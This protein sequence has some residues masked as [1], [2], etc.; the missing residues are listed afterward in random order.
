MALFT[1]S[2]FVQFKHSQCFMHSSTIIRPVIWMFALQTDCDTDNFIVHE[3]GCKK[4]VGKR[5]STN[6]VLS[7]HESMMIHK[8]VLNAKMENTHCMLPVTRRE[9]LIDASVRS[10]PRL[11][12]E[13][14][15]LQA[16]SSEHS[17]S[18]VLLVFTSLYWSLLLDIYFLHLKFLVSRMNSI[19]ACSH[20][21]LSWAGPLD[22]V[23][24]VN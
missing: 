8:T 1:Y 18:I 19:S 11:A 3:T 15:K 23:L 9:K 17:H 2:I 16:V 5:L 6:L 21:L 7:L 13:L 14:L 24:L 10:I 22:H 20:H 4:V 12:R